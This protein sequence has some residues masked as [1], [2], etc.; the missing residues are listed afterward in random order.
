MN[1]I[2]YEQSLHALV[3]SFLSWQRE[4]N[5]KD[6]EAYPPQMHLEEWDEMFMAYIQRR[7]EDDQ[8]KPSKPMPA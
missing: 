2:D 7:L 1:I 5:K 4:M 8:N 6:P 3:D